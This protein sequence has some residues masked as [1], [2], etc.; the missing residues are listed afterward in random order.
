[1][2]EDEEGE[3]KTKKGGKCERDLSER[4]KIGIK[5]EREKRKWKYE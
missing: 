1:M 5:K 3:K 4:K 2:K